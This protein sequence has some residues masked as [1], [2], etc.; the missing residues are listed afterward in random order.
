MGAGWPVRQQPEVHAL[1]LSGFVQLVQPIEH[2]LHQFIGAASFMYRQSGP[3]R[4]CAFP[5]EHAFPF[6][7]NIDNELGRVFGERGEAG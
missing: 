2:R 1:L 5:V 3:Y 4:R 6:E 7:Y